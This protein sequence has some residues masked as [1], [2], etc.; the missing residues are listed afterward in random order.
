[1]RLLLSIL[2]SGAFAA[3]IA[4]GTHYE[5]VRKGVFGIYASFDG[6]VPIADADVLIFSPGSTTPCGTTSTDMRGFFAFVPDTSGT[7]V[8]QVRD[9]T[10]HGMRINLPVDNNH[11]VETVESGITPTAKV[12]MA[13]SII[14]GAIGTALFFSG[15]RKAVG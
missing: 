5:V 6:K 14:W 11:I 7:W 13:V 12:V 8:L 3:T 2:L 1:M 10:G 15:R 9:K 4:H